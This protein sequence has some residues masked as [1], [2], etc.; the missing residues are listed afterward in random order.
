MIKTETAAIQIVVNE[1]AAALEARRIE[2]PALPDMV[3]RVRRALDNPNASLEQLV[4]VVSSDPVV[5]V[6]VIKAANSG[7][8]HGSEKVDNLRA[9]ISRIGYRM[10]YGIVTNVALTK[11]LRAAKPLIGRQLRRTWQHSCEVAA[12]CYVLAE[13]ENGLRP[14][15]AMLAGL[16]FRIGALPLCLHADR[17]IVGLDQET[18]DELVSSHAAA[19]S[20]TVLRQWDFPDD[21]VRIVE[22]YA[23]PECPAEPGSAAYIDVLAL[24]EHQARRG[25][26][27]ESWRNLHSAERLGFY[28]GDCRSFFSS[29]AD[30]VAEMESVLGLKG[31]H[32]VRQRKDSPLAIA[33]PEVP[34][35]AGGLLHSLRR[36]FGS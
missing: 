6:H 16:V 34:R 25:G 36:M 19:I 13:R 15:V 4:H 33:A 22:G 30:R 8:F 20:A 24:S 28:P 11:L 23:N 14:E 5:A 21:V 32:P 18:L 9:A 26:D 29:K 35:S 2:L 31:R 27:K 1:V 17:L 12:N 3:V 10:L 7:A